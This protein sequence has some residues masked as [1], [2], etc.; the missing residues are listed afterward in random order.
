MIADYPQELCKNNNI[1]NLPRHPDEHYLD[2][3]WKSWYDFLGKQ[4]T[5]KRNNDEKRS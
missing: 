4:Q 1:N 2:K 3:G 5:G